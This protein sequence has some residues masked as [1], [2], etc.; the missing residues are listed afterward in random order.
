MQKIILH[1]WFD[2]QAKES[3]EVYTSLFKDSQ[4]ESIKTITGTPSGDCDIV[5]FT[6]AGQKFM[7]ISAGPIFKLNPSISLFTVF[8]SEEEITRVWNKL[9]EGGK[10]LMPF[11]TYPWA[12]K[13]GWLEDKYGLSWQLSLSDFHQ[14]AQ[15]I[16]PMMM[17]T[18][19]MAGKT[20]EAME[21]YTS[22]FPNSQIDLEVKYEKEDGDNIDYLKHARFTLNGQHFLAM[23]SSLDHKF[24]F[25]EAFSLMVICDTQEEI[26]ELWNKLSAVPEA[27]NCGWLKDQYGVSWQ[28]V[29]TAMNEMMSNGTPEQ[30]SRVTQA[31]LKMKKFDIKTLEKA[32]TQN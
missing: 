20:H 27:E 3:A 21:K 9:N 12:R 2:T 10:V 31:F 1:L 30:I 14:M 7:S 17:F 22:L 19:K 24:T 25:N 5:S 13:Y 18:G 28:I 15:K 8:D 32:Y 16:T 11:D 23:D 29:P 6:L 4:V 26:D